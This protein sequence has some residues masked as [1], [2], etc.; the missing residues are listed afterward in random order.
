MHIVHVSFVHTRIACPCKGMRN[1]TPFYFSSNYRVQ[2]AVGLGLFGQTKSCR[3]HKLCPGLCVGPV[4]PQTVKPFYFTR[5]DINHTNMNECFAIKSNLYRDKDYSEL[6][7]HS[8]A[9][10]RCDICAYPECI[11]NNSTFACGNVIYWILNNKSCVIV[12]N[13]N[14]K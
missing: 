7:L 12:C 10:R 2:W 13:C 5:I 3:N 1:L 14:G 6:N 11:L 4:W 8:Y 9:S